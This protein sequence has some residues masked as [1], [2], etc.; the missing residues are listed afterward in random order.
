MT[1]NPILKPDHRQ[2]FRAN[3]EIIS[4]GNWFMPILVVDKTDNKVP[5]RVCEAYAHDHDSSICE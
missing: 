2:R 4:E 3:F 5:A 1:D